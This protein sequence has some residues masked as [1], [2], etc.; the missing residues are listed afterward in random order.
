MKKNENENG[1]EKF[2]RECFYR[3]KLMRV[4]ETT[5]FSLSLLCVVLKNGKKLDCRIEWSWSFTTQTFTISCKNNI[6]LASAWNE[7]L[8]HQRRAMQKKIRGRGRIRVRSLLHLSARCDEVTVRDRIFATL[9][10]VVDN[11]HKHKYT[12]KTLTFSANR[13]RRQFRFNY[14]TSALLALVYS[15]KN[16]CNKP[17]YYV[18]ILCPVTTQA[19]AWS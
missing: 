7:S 11:L 8:I 17:A 3:Y 4:H 1:S 13:R 5:N 19:F 2:L 14:S 12:H 15:K 9:R 16:T 6:T 18:H 10:S